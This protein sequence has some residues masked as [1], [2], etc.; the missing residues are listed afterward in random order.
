MKNYHIY[1][2]GNALVDI[3]VEVTP[4]ELAR[5]EIEK[6]V[7]TLVD[8]ERQEYLLDAL[9]G[10]HHKKACG[11]SAANT[12]IGAAKLGARC[13]YSC[14]I[15]DDELGQF[16][17]ADLEREGV[18]SNLS[19]LQLEPGSTGRCI[20][21]VSPDADRTMNTYLGITG[22][23]SFEQVDE[24]ALKQSEWLYIEGYLVSSDS[25]RQA[26]VKTRELAEREG[27]KTALSLSDPNM[28]KFFKDG[29][30]EM[31]GDGVDLLFANHD[32]A[33][34]FTGAETLEAAFEAL[35]RFAKQFVVTLG[36]DGALLWDGT[37]P[38]KINAYPVEAVD[39]NGAGDLFAGA[40]LYAVTHGYSL[41][42]AAKL[43][44][45]SSARLVK[46]FGPRLSAAGQD[47]VLEY[48]KEL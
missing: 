44:S 24:A 41:E 15:A 10:T 26:A 47:L 7:M 3:E 46:E 16:Y 13:F 27:L 32:E 21:M 14:K 5:L 18:T 36:A 37:N 40:F 35:K 19:Q 48:L 25:A 43:A 12:V 6:G 45:F 9:P 30:T 17:A 23:I 11:G 42:K 38:V 2:I 39:T 29:L 33:L 22:D 28:V 34:L 8:H 20:V 1:G 31:I 4:E